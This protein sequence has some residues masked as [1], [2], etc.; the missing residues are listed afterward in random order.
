MTKVAV[1]YS[2]EGS[3]RCALGDTTFALNVRCA[4]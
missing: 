1:S 2:I 3:H 4:H